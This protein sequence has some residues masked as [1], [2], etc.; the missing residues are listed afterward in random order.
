MKEQIKIGF[1]LDRTLK[2]FDINAGK[3]AKISRVSPSQISEFRK[4]K[5]N[6]GSD[7]IDRVLANLDGMAPGSLNY[8]CWQLAGGKPSL[9]DEIAY[10]Q[11]KELA[12]L[13]NAIADKLH[14]AN[15]PQHVGILAS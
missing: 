3:L 13:L 14:T 12:L 7:A 10:L 1:A 5:R 11:P 15:Q 6:L 2:H 8:F 4:G 9:Q